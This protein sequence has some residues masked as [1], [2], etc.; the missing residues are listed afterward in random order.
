MLTYG[1]LGN[2]S[3][4]RLV[5]ADGRVCFFFNWMGQRKLMMSG[6]FIFLLWMEKGVE[7][8]SLELS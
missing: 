8:F 2:L 6:T 4:L 3:V 5:L 7:T 1:Q